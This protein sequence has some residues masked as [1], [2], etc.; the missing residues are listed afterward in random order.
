MTV[1]LRLQLLTEACD[2]GLDARDNL[3]CAS[4]VRRRDVVRLRCDRLPGIVPL[5]L[6]GA[7]R[8]VDAVVGDEH[9]AH[10]RRSAS[11][12]VV[13]HDH[14]RLPHESHQAAVLDHLVAGW[15]R[16]L[17]VRPPRRI[18]HQPQHTGRGEPL[19]R[20]EHDLLAIGPPVVRRRSPHFVGVEER[21]EHVVLSGTG[22]RLVSFH[23][24]Y[25][26]VE[27]PSTF[28]SGP[29]GT[30]DRLDEIRG[31]NNGIDEEKRRSELTRRPGVPDGDAEAVGD[32]SASSFSK[33]TMESGPLV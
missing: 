18:G 23:R 17:R 5:R 8:L 31:P 22:A 26:R 13:F 2:C 11:R 7:K 15:L 3:L 21:G 6:G 33:G 9:A 24:L 27:V 19:H 25:D 10:E 30:L 16:L 12:L 1:P 32:L 28:K 29:P 14:A 4:S 20:P